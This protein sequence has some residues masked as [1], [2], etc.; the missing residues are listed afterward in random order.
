MNIC[1]RFALLRAIKRGSGI[2]TVRDTM[3]N[4]TILGKRA[5]GVAGAISCLALLAGC[6]SLAGTEQDT[7]TP[8]LSDRF[9]QVFGTRAQQPVGTGAAVA[10]ASGAES[11]ATD[12]QD[13]PEVF[14]RNGAGTYSLGVQGREAAGADLR[15]QVTVT[16]MARECRLSG[17]QVM[18]SVGI[19]GRVILGPAGA[20]PNADV[21]L[22]IA[23]VQEGT[24][25]KTIFSKFYQSSVPLPPGQ[26]NVPYNFVAEDVVYPVPRG[27][28]GDSYVFY[29]GFDPSGMRAAP[30]PRKGKK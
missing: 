8:M 15:Y 27:A 30:Q 6:G 4:R 9:G 20:P 28:A 12:I 17:G 1:H 21:P 10:S 24:S 29:I 2:I 14:V 13:C 7:W 16:D 3:R 18:A 5:A 19:R 25:P 23:L 11:G 22:R 26:N